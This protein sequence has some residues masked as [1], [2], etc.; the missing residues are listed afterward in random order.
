MREKIGRWFVRFGARILQRGI[1]VGLDGS[2][3]IPPIDAT[4]ITITFKG[5]GGWGG[6]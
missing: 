4:R 3:T 6:K 5:A 2:M 1:I